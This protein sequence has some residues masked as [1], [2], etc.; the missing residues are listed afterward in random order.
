LRGSV[1]FVFVVDLWAGNGAAASPPGGIIVTDLF[2]HGSGSG[3]TATSACSFQ[4][5]SSSSFSA[6]T[7]VGDGDGGHGVLW[8]VPL[9]LV[10]WC[11]IVM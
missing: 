10:H 9:D 3:S 7:I 2:F 11:L 1:V 5:R 8:F 6:A 4:F